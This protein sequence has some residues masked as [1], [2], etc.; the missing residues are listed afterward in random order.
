MPNSCEVCKESNIWDITLDS[1]PSV[2]WKAWIFQ[3]QRPK[4]IIISKPFSEALDEL[5]GSI[6]KFKLHSLIKNVKSDYFQSVKQDLTSEK[7]I[8]E[9][10]FTENY[11]L[12]SQDEIQSAH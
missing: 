11:T 12:I 6:P 5:H 2:N 8:V 1:N 3:N 4:Q 7:A 9:I 10:D